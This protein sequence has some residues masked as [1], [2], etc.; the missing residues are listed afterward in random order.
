MDT[1]NKWSEP[2]LVVICSICQ[3][4]ENHDD[5]IRI[6]QL[7]FPEYSDFSIQAIVEKYN[8]VACKRSTCCCFIS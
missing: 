7:I 5:R 6:L 1:K 8:N 2:E 3:W 4:K